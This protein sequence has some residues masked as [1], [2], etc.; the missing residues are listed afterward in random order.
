[1]LQAEQIEELVLV[2]QAMDR[3]T[4]IDQMTHYQGA[5]PV[6]FTADFLSTLSLDR[7]R[8][9]FL[10]VCIQSSRIPSTLSNAA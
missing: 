8:H 1:M 2:V 3:E 6:D 4:L 9:I 10:A 7:L 5:F